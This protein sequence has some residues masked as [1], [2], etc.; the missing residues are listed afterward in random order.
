MPA[1]STG[2]SGPKFVLGVDGCRAGWVTARLS[3]SDSSII[4]RVAAS[5][6]D[7]L[8]GAK[9]D[10]ALI[11][12][13]MPIGLA[14]TGR[15]ACEGMARQLLKPKRHAS[16]FSTPRR[17]M[18]AY[19]DYA[20]ANAWGK[21]QGKDAGGGLS[22]QAWMITPKIREIDALIEPHNQRRIGEAHP[23]VAFW[24]LN[25]RAPCAHSKRTTQGME[26]RQTILMKSGVADPESLFQSIRKQTGA[27]VGR[28]DVYDACALALSAKARLN[29]EAIHLTDG[30][31]DASG[32]IMEIWG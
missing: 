13:D 17:P 14:E 6:A 16:V 1:T 28:D 25:Q 26:E 9:T 27:S 7:I 10:T 32:L 22:K 5:F 4:L 15:R 20:D 31:R 12:I 19:N 24:R 2:K 11:H 21:A 23:E 30:A 3:L 8:N 18:L 29:G